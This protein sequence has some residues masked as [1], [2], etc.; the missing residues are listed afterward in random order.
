[1]P[2]N[3]ADT[4]GSTAEPAPAPET[5]ADRLK[6]RWAEPE[7]PVPP[8]YRRVS[9]RTWKVSGGV[10]AALVAAGLLATVLG[11][12]D[13]V[14]NRLDPVQSIGDLARE[15]DT[16]G[17]YAARNAEIFPDTLAYLRFREHFV[18]GYRRPGS[19]GTDFIVI[20]AT[21]NFSS[22]VRELDDLLGGPDPSLA[23]VTVGGHA[24][25]APTAPYTAFPAG[26][27]GGALKCSATPNGHGD[28]LA[29]CAW[30][31]FTTVGSVT[32]LTQNAADLDLPGLA[33]RTRT[34]RAAMTSRVK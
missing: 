27:L 8:W 10:L 15:P 4:T 16:S 29:V 18:T 30:A 20:G 22:P 7:G 13:P 2:N 21:G 32:D 3:D 19:T 14:R 23:P 31:D 28:V 11:P 1:M 12:D 17:S 25:Q 5:S 6:S 34:I 33:E 9:R 24:P 26:P